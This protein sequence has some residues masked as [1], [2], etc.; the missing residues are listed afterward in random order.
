MQV[1]QLHDVLGDW[2]GPAGM[3]PVVIQVGDCWYEI[4]SVNLDPDTGEVVIHAGDEIEYEYD[5][6][7]EVANYNPNFQIPPENEDTPLGIEDDNPVEEPDDEPEDESENKS[8]DEEPDTD[9]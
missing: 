5:G 2:G 9:H 3:A 1:G 6:E 4:D 7:E 8:E